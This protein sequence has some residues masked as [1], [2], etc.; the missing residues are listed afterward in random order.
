MLITIGS[1]VLK[2]ILVNNTS[3]DALKKLLNENPLI[4][5]M[6]DYGNFEKVGPI[7]T[8]LPRNDVRITTEPGDIIL[9]LGSNL[10]L[11]YNTNTYTFTRIGKI[12]DVTQ[13]ELKKIL[14][15]GSV[16]VTF[17]NTIQFSRKYSISIKKFIIV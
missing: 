5:Q 10:C 3:T 16:T 1:T 2:S 9:Y 14:G 15:D 11:Y 8:T 7:G 13:D 6:N 4:I 12:Q 17:W